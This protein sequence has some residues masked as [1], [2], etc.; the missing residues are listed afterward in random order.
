MEVQLVVLPRSWPHAPESAATNPCQFRIRAAGPPHGAPHRRPASDV[1][2]D[3]DGARCRLRDPGHPRATETGFRTDRPNVRQG[4]ANRWSS[5]RSCARGHQPAARPGILRH[6]GLRWNAL[7]V[8]GAHQS[9]PPR[10]F[11]GSVTTSRWPNPDPERLR[12]A[13]SAAAPAAQTACAA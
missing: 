4:A 6:R 8:G 1:P 7:R 11:P 13:R 3:H 12:P 9:R 2:A 10:V 5:T